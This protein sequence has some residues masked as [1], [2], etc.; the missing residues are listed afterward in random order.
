[1]RKFVHIVP[2]LAILILGAGCTE[3]PTSPENV[4]TVDIKVNGSD[5]PVTLSSGESWNYSWTSAGATVCQLTSPT[6]TSGVTLAGNGGPINPDHPWYPTAG[7]QITLVFNC[8]NGNE[9][10]TDS[11]VVKI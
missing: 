9:S 3:N 2:L 6:G 5:G 1:M 11:V 10:A 7:Q 8:S 4:I